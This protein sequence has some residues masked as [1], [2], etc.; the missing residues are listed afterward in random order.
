MIVNVFR[1]VLTSMVLGVGFVLMVA[2]CR[3]YEPPRYERLKETPGTPQVRV[4]LIGNSLT[5]YNDMPGLLQQLS[6]HEKAPIYVEQDTFPLRKLSGAWNGGGP[7]KRIRNGHWDYVVLQE[8]SN[9]P[10]VDLDE[11]L[12]YFMLFNDEV[13]RSGAKTI[14]FQNWTREGSEGEFGK[15]QAAYK[16]IQQ[17]TGG[18]LAPIGPAVRD[19]TRNRPDIELLVDDRHPSEAASYLTACVLYNVI[20]GKKAESLAMDL[21]GPNLPAEKLMALKRAAD[22]AVSGR[23]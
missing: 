15:M 19:I 10:L 6:K 17:R 18:T 16:T 23:E 5:Y 12:K 1:R 14:I 4:L 22:R 9:L 2:S 3:L 11:S 8:Y 20:Y 21:P 7:L 13:K